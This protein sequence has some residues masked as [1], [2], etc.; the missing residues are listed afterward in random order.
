MT[1]HLAPE[2]VWLAHQL[3]AAY[4]PEGFEAEGFIHCTDGEAL[5]ID[6]GNRYYR[7]DPRPYVVLDVD[8][9]R[10]SAPVVYEDEA[11]Q[12]PHIYG[13]IEREAVSRVRR[14]VRGLDGAF[15]SIGG[16]CDGVTT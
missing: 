8:L 9:A 6:V 16:P 15:L 4:R 7:D 10:V 11:R 13:P 12:F 14:V 5:L 3:Q 1:F 2:S